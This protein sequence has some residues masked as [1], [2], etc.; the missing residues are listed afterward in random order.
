MSLRGDC[1]TCECAGNHPEA[2]QICHSGVAH[3]AAKCGASYKGPH[4]RCHKCRKSKTQFAEKKEH[5][6]YRAPR[7]EGRP[8]AKEDVPLLTDAR[9]DE[10]LVWATEHITHLLLESAKARKDRTRLEAEVDRLRC[11]S[12]RQSAQALKVA[13][14]LE[15]LSKACDPPVEGTP[16][17]PTSDALLKLAE[18]LAPHRQQPREEG[19]PTK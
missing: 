7:K 18:E 11:E 14:S 17:T 8:T 1:R 12:A 13:T 15:A 16:T 19:K 3:E 4:K 10:L 2:K 9:K 5:N 6:G